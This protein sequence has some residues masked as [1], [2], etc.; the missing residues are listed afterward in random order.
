MNK[1]VVALVGSLMATQSFSAPLDN[2]L[3]SRISGEVVETTTEDCV[4]S[5]IKNTEPVVGKDASGNS[6]LVQAPANLAIHGTRV[7]AYKV[8][9]F[10]HV[11][12][13]HKVTF[14]QSK[15]YIYSPVKCHK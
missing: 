11:W 13:S 5:V 2:I 1:L 6:I 12:K 3:M 10:I 4:V 14:T 9:T 7:S 15:S 8:T